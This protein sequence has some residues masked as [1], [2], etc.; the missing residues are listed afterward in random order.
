MNNNRKEQRVIYIGPIGVEGTAMAIHTRNIAKIL[1]LIGYQLTF[2]CSCVPKGNKE[3]N[4]DKYGYFYTK[5]WIKAPKLSTIEWM[6]EELSG[7]KLFRLFK[8]KVKLI[9]PEV[10]IF[11]GYSGQKKIINYCKRNGITVIVDRTDWFEVSDHTGVFGR[12]FAKYFSNK[13]ILKHD[14]EANGVISI[15]KYF[16]DFYTNRGQNTIW[17]PPVFEIEKNK[18]FFKR[19]M[20]TIQLVYAGSLGGTKDIIEPIVEIIFSKYNKEKIQFTLNLVGIT[21]EQLDSK[22]GKHNWKAIG[23]NAY[24]R[25]PHKEAEEIVSKSDF[26]FLLRQNK[27]YAK[28]GF[29]TK[30]SESLSH[31]V[32]VICT[33]VGGADILVE[34]MK[35]GVLIDNN[36]SYTIERALFEILNLTDKEILNMKNAAYETALTYFDYHSYEESLKAFINYD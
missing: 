1:E 19:N 2:L 20:D 21:E 28:A 5:Q 8:K 33:K 23:I 25:L 13:S 29:S 35:N 15:S 3:Y 16:Y 12:F 34:H 7:A 26:S 30:F 6:I 24:G 14:F 32:P 10:V 11:Y 31:G 36:D 27:R 9:N 18:C 22:F 4:S 17:L